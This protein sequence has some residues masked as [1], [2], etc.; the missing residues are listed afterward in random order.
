VSSWSAREILLGTR[1]RISGTVYGTIVVMAT[2]S[3][4]GKGEVDAW[5]LAVLVFATVFVF[6]VAHVYADGLEESIERGRRLDRR[7]FLEV[8]RREAAIVLAAVGPLAALVLGAAGVLRESRAIWL[9]LAF[10]LFVLAIQGVRYAR[11]EHM[12]G[13]GTF[14]AVAINLGLGL[15]IVALKVVLAH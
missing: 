8:A 2:I 12:R 3:A 6:W 7:E 10:G 13:L 5:R 4:G 11:L 15:V 14:G 1:A 9:A